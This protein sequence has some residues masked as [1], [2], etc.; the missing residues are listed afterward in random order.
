MGKF[1]NIVKTTASQA[2]GALAGVTF[3]KITNKI[4]N[5]ETVSGILGDS[6][7]TVKKYVTPILCIGAGYLLSNNVE[8]TYLKDF[9]NGVVVAGALDLGMEICFKKNLLS[10]SGEGII[11]SILGDV[12][13]LE[14]DDEDFNGTDV[15]SVAVEAPMQIGSPSPNFGIGEIP[16]VVFEGIQPMSV[17]GFM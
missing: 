17:G 16:G 12:D 5:G 3:M 9:A 2:G 4:V 7:D 8:G 1:I 14:G 13:D 10:G 15:E 11:G 6:A